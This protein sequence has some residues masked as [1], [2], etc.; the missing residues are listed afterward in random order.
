M[1][2]PL[3]RIK[4]KYCLK[5]IFIY[6]NYDNI[7][8]L[9]KNNKKLKKK[10]GL[11][12]DNYKNRSSYR[13]LEKQNI[14]RNYYSKGPDSLIFY[15]SLSFT[16]GFFVIVLLSALLFLIFPFGTLKE[17]DFNDSKIKNYFKIIRKINLSLFGLLI[18]IIITY[19]IIFIWAIYDCYSDFGLITKI[20]KSIL[21]I[22]SL[23]YLIYD[24]VIIV[25]LSLSY[26]IAKGKG[27]SKM[28]TI[29]IDY[30]LLIFIFLYFSFIVVVISCYFRHV[31]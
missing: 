1:S 18:Y 6:V 28:F 5:E 17:K 12:I 7:L 4:S 31:G 23:L 3:L 20:K 2:Q 9:I 13:C 11:N 30:V 15:F 27:I 21:I 14:M 10:L 26:K 25:K 19:I 29:I 24:I 8:R 22:I 16:I